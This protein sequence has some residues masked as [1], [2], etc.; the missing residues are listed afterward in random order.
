MVVI[1]DKLVKMVH[2]GKLD[3]VHKLLLVV[4]AV[5]QVRQDCM[6]LVYLVHLTT[7]GVQFKANY[8]I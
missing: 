2:Q 4:K 8:E 3:L 7:K 6:H 1:L 5:A